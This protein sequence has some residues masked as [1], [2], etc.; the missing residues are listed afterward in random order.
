MAQPQW[1]DKEFAAMPS[2]AVAAH[3][4]KAPLALIRQMSLLIEDG[5][6][7]PAEAQLMQRRLTLTA[8][9]SL[10][11]VQD[12]AHTVNVQPTLFP[13][14]PVNP[15]ALLAQLAHQSRDML[16]LYDRRVTWPRAGKKWLVVANP[17]LL[18]RIMTNFLDNA[19]RYSEAGAVIRVT[20]HQAGTMVRLGVRDFGPMMSLAEYRRLVDEMT[21]RKSVRTRPD[22]S[23]LGV[24]IAATFARAMGGQI[25]LIRHRDGL[26][27]YVDVPLSEQMSLL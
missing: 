3:E 17:L 6:L 11:L 27:F 13:L 26:T 21:T 12:L 14:E 16:R 25:G 20:M 2:I 7:S 4:L 22:S 24:Y 5:Q 19:M 15:L 1:S 23:G 9:R 10:A 8:E 18:G